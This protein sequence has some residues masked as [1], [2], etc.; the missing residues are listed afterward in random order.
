[1]REIKFRGWNPEGNYGGKV[2]GNVY[3]MNDWKIND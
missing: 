3:Q 1:M 2:I